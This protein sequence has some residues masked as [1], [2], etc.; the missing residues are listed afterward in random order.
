MQRWSHDYEAVGRHRYSD[1]DE[2]P[3]KQLCSAKD[4]AVE[5]Q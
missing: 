5:M 4:Y 2:A 3:V 1:G